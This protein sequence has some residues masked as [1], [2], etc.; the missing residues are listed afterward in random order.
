MRYE[1]FNGS[2]EQYA[3]GDIILAFHNGQKRR[4][5]ITEKYA[6]VKNGEPGWLGIWIDHQPTDRP[7]LESWGYDYQIEAI[8]G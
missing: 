4:F 3:E 1:D 2:H 6:D 7:P 5:Q 8:V